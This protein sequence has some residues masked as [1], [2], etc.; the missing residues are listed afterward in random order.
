MTPGRGS[1]LNLLL[2][3]ADDQRPAL[4]KDVAGQAARRQG[5]V[6]NIKP[7][8]MWAEDRP[9]D[10]FAQ[11]WSVIVPDGAAGKRL[12]AIIEP[13]IKLRRA[14]QG[15]HPVAIYTVRPDLS[16]LEADEWRRRN[17]ESQN[18]LRA[19]MPRY[20][21]ILGDLDQVAMTT[22]LT[23]AADG[24]VGRLAFSDE[25][26]YAAYVEKV[27]RWEQRGAQSA[28]AD[29]RFFTVHDGTGA[30]TDGYEKLMAPGFALAESLRDFRARKIERLGSFDEPDPDEF[31]RA[32]ADAQPAVMLS[33]SHGAGPPRK[34]GWKSLADQRERQGAMSFGNANGLLTAADIA[35]RQFL[36]GGVWFMFACYGAGTPQRSAYR[37]WLEVLKKAGQDFGPIDDVLRGL[38][39]DGE[40]PFIAALPQAALRNPGGPLAF[41][42]HIDLAWSF[43]YEELD[44]KQGPYHRPGRYIAVLRSLLQGHRV[45]PAFRELTLFFGQI[46]TTLTSTADE[47]AAG[48]PRP[49]TAEEEARRGY[50]WMARQD[51]AGYM[52][53]GDPAV[54]L[55]I[56]AGIAAPKPIAKAAAPVDLSGLFGFSVQTTVQSTDRISDRSSEKAARLPIEKL[57]NAIG[58][59]LVSPNSAE[60][61]ASAAGIDVGELRRLTELYRRAGRSAIDRT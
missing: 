16:Y 34:A 48:P 28:Q 9:D 35:N 12:L 40:K 38:P 2:C 33:L 43:G 17:F 45:G 54:R 55:P 23:Q 41:L 25:A 24:Y 7:L 22:Q 20:Q 26:G 47:F 46:N 11:R 32:T 8:H 3:D 30:T 36:P 6:Q 5:A 58:Q 14:Q 10:L 49:P 56:E 57:E 31:L 18:G 19:E 39:K 4:D 1:N 42:G 60:Q 50:L 29:A 13:L 21:L 15:D 52:L 37:H 44:S 51:L 61:I 59:M 27:L 53:L